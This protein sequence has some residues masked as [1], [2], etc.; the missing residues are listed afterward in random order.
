MPQQPAELLTL[1]NGKKRRKKNW[2]RLKLQRRGRKRLSED[3][4][5]LLEAEV[6]V[7]VV[8][9]V[10]KVE[11]GAENSREEVVVDGQGLHGIL[12]GEDFH[13]LRKIGLLRQQRMAMQTPTKCVNSFFTNSRPSLLLLNQ[14]EGLSTRILKSSPKSSKPSVDFLT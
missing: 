13:R 14:Q 6:V 7:E 11:E 1:K 3:L 2:W 5:G 12:Q 8:V 4:I 9:A 10:V